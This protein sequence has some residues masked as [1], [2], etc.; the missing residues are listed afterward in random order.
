MLVVPWLT[1]FIVAITAIIPL[2][3]S[4]RMFF[5]QLFASFGMFFTTPF[6]SFGNFGLHNKISDLF[7]TSASQS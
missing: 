3:A 2:F 6:A 7:S 1:L 5:E 4:F